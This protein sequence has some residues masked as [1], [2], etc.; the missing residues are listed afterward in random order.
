M[1]AA[2][3]V[4]AVRVTP[5]GSVGGEE[6]FAE[7]EHVLE[8]GGAVALGAAESAGFDELEDHGPDIAVLAD[9][10]GV[11]DGNGH[12]PVFLLGMG[13]EAADQFGTGDM[14]VF[15]GLVPAQGS[16]GVVERVPEEVVGV[17]VETGIPRA[18]SPDSGV[19]S[20]GLHG[21]AGEEKQ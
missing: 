4:G 19:E 3:G 9:A 5:G 17:C 8:I 7:V 11:E 2:G 15:L 14:A 10:P 21:G 18:D 1:G 13:D 16:H 12:G 20:V 6:S